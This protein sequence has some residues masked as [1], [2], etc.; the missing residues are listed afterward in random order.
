MN[1][2]RYNTGIKYLLLFTIIL[3]SCKSTKKAYNSDSHFHSKIQTHIAFERDT[4]L[5]GEPTYAYFVV[6]NISNESFYVCR[7]CPIIAKFAQWPLVTLTS[8]SNEALKSIDSGVRLGSRIDSRRL[9]P[10]ESIKF[11]LFL[12]DYWEKIT[13]EGIHEL[14]ITK[15][16]MVGY[17]YPSSSTSRKPK[18]EIQGDYLIREESAKFLVKNDSLLLGEFI[19]SLIQSIKSET[20]NR[21]VDMN[22]FVNK[23]KK[24]ESYN[25][26]LR[27]SYKKLNHINDKRIVPFLLDSYI[28]NNNIPKGTS[29]KSLIKFS[30]DSLVFETLKVATQEPSISICEVSRDS[31]LAGWNSWDLSQI[32]IRAIMNEDTEK[33]VDFLVAQKK[34]AFLC[35]RY[36][37]LTSLNYLMSKENAIKICEAYLTDP[38]KAIR[39]K[40]REQMDLILQK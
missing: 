13:E 14:K 20:N 29:L 38:H 1:S 10:G 36:R 32:A 35:D 8:P 17:E 24:F 5:I 34:D 30:S 9:L 28:Y 21:E 3:F 6:S 12:D 23:D 33:A 37:I 2:N 40:A 4:I 26:K 7:N 27:E 22:G 19:E 31:I 39:R 15:H 25:E 16:M 18:F 11:E